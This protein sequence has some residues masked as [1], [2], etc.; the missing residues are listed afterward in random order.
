MLPRLSARS[1]T[2]VLLALACA[3]TLST[4]A[5]GRGSVDAWV[6]VSGGASITIAGGGYGHGHGMSQYGALGAALAGLRYPQILAFYYPGTTLTSQKG[7]IRVLISADTDKN[8]IVRGAP[9]LRVVDR[10]L[11]RA[12]PLPVRDASGASIRLWRL[13]ASAGKTVLAYR[14][15]AGWTTYRLE[16]RAALAGNGVFRSASKRLTLRVGSADRVY[17]G[18]MMLSG[19]DTINLL[20]M[21]AYLRSVVPAEMPASWSAEAVRAQSVAARTYA[22]W[23][24]A[25]RPSARWHICDTTACQVYAGVAAE[26]PASSAAVVATTGQILTY[27]GSP[28]FTQF[29]ASSGGWTAQGSRPY[30]AAKVDPYDATPANKVHTWSK[31]VDPSVL[32]RAYPAL[33]TLVRMR[34]T[35]RDGNGQWGGRVTTLS[36]D[37]SASDVTITG[38][39]ARSLLGLR[40]TL[41]TLE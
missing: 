6:P 11:K 37:G 32:Q 26:H 35:G 38:D 10:G 13:K 27:Q 2:A 25:Q 31:A 7:G 21:N 39:R 9:G 12:F 16:G 30:L 34:V 4:A 22:M 17:R 33:G 41:F 19:T 8:V 20:A 36:L 14:A 40:S 29:S 1:V 28:A 23:S 3:L 18:R 24:K 15:S 5:S